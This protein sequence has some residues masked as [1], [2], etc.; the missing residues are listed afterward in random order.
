MR[1]EFGR[2]LR[3]ALI[4]REKFLGYLVLNSVAF[5]VTG[6]I[7]HIPLRSLSPPILVAGFAALGFVLTLSYPLTKMRSRKAMID[8]KLPHAITYMQS[9]VASLPLYE[10]IRKI[11]E[12]KE[13]YGEVAEEFALVVRDVELF[14]FTVI[15][16]LRELASSTP[17]ENLRE[18]VEGLIIT[19]DSGGDLREYLAS[20][21]VQFR[22]RAARSMEINLKTLEILAEVFVVVFVALPIF[23]VVMMTSMNIVGKTVGREF[24][25]FLYLFL[26]LGGVALVFVIDQMNVKEDLSLTR[27]ERKRTYY[28][29]EIVADRNTA[30]ITNI[31]TGKRDMNVF[32]A[33]K[34][35]YYYSL[36]F[37]PIPTLLFVVLARKYLTFRFPE[38]LIAASIIL[39]CL[40]LLIAFE[41]RSW[42][43][44][45]VEKDI[46]ELLRQ[47]LNLKDVGLTLQGVIDVIKDSK[48]GVLERELKIVDAD[49]E[50]GATI[51]EALTEFINRTGVASIRRVIS[52]II[53]ATQVTENLRDILLISLEDF[54]HSLK[55][56][57][58]RY[59]TGFAYLVVIY[60]SFFTFLYTAYSLNTSFLSSL[61]SLTSLNLVQS[62]E[63][64]Y[65]VSILLALFSGIIAGQLEKGHVLHGLKHICIFTLSAVVLFEFL[66]GGG[67]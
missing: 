19:F 42:Y 5:G 62:Q 34:L 50:W 41:Y 59:I 24:Y 55:I 57:S 56:K 48:I 11:S 16:A 54:E 66:I 43:V 28:P 31:D 40:P 20:K 12:E 67:T 13:L 58:D 18:F 44:R 10:V 46:P 35:N 36:I 9:M 63:M 39:F 45:K 61:T 7:M 60:V 53:E 32:K 37:S 17:S 21:S 1:D 33:I 3:G 30:S 15:D 27:I 26:P 64:M 65:R 38:T 25:Y 51:A 47:M 52:L 4:P 29:P 8:L 2:V 22:E 14:G 49:I 6:Y 23:L